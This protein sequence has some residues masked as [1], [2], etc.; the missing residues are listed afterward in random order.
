LRGNYRSSRHAGR[1]GVAAP[2]IRPPQNAT[3]S[4]TGIERGHDSSPPETSIMMEHIGFILFYLF[5]IVV[6]I[7][8][9]NGTLEE[10]NIEWLLYVLAVAVFP[11]VLFL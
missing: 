9:F 5:A 7:L 8:H 6:L 4:L 1:C 2:T 10:Y 3:E 11:A